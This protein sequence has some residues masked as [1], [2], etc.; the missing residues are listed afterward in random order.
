MK[1]HYWQGRKSVKNFGDELNPW[2]WPKILGEI[3]DDSE[4]EI[5]VG[6]GTILN[7]TIPRARQTVVMGAGVG[8]GSLPLVDDSWRFY[9]VRGR[10]STEALGLPLEIAITDPAILVHN[11]YSVTTKKKYPFAFMPHWTTMHSGWKQVCER[12]G[13][14]LINPLDPVESVLASIGD[15]EVLLAEAMHGAIVADALRIPWIPVETESADRLPSKWEDWCAT[16][17]IPYQ[18]RAI[19]GL[20]PIQL[21]G[22]V[23]NRWYT[24]GKRLVRN[25]QQRRAASQLSKIARRVKPFLSRDAVLR[26]LLQRMTDAIDRFR[27]DHARGVFTAADRD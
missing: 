16:V 27:T 2:L 12:L 5:F 26:E 13:F 15:T 9:A 25:Y 17:G 1:L 22:T 24:S 23:S 3:L 6:I 21:E 8:Y 4:D 10:L 14:G 19:S 18:P 7:D 20:R 11:H